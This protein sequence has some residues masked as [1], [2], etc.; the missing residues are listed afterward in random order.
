M[1]FL[2][3]RIFTDTAKNFYH[4]LRGTPQRR[5]EWSF[6][7]NFTDK[8][9]LLMEKKNIRIS[10]LSRGSGIPYTTI[11]GFYK[12]GYNNIKLSTLR[13]LSE[14]FG[15][16]IDYLVN[17]NCD[18]KNPETDS[19]ENDLLIKYRCLDDKGKQEVS[20][21]LETNYERVTRPVLPYTEEDDFINIP[22]FED[23]AAAGSGYMLGEGNYEM[24]KVARSR[25]SERAD[26][27]VTVSGS[28]MEP[29]YFDGDNVLVHSQPDVYVGEIGIFVVNGDGYIKQKGKNR[30][31][32]INKKYKDVYVNEYDNIY[33]AGKVVGKLEDDEILS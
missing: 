8:L 3:N 28:S 6:D 15:V 2:L 31:I 14:Y 23:R 33:C 12:K 27:I 19:E 22:Y 5:K 32:S 7:M 16:S 26:F 4:T 10:D 21:V 9:N 13:Q 18:I 17:D 1:K 20:A 30:L 29:E 25:K 11:D 24:M